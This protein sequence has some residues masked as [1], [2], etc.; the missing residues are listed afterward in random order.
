MPRMMAM[1][2]TAPFSQVATIMRCSPGS[3]GT[4]VGK[5]GA[6]LA[7]ANR[8]R[9][10]FDQSICGSQ[11]IRPNIIGSNIEKVRRQAFLQ[12]LQ[13]VASLRVVR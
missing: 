10:F 6:A 5:D 12:K 11:V 13:R 2:S 1:S 7:S 8:L 4:L 3:S 9:R